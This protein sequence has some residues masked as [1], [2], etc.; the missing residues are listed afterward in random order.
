M[1]DFSS[2]VKKELEVKKIS[3]SDF[4]QKIGFSYQYVYDLLKGRGKRRWNENSINEACKAL[5]IEIQFK[6]KPVP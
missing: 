1:M 2:I 3:V 4:A 6:T 5:G